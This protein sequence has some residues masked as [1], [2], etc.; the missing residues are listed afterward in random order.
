MLFNSTFF[1]FIF[2]PITLF[3]YYFF[4]NSGKLKIAQTALVFFS[5]FFY[6]WWNYNYFFLIIV[7]ILFNYLIGK[8]LLKKKKKLILIFG[9]LSNLLV[10]FY[11]KYHNFFIENINVIFEK[12]ILIFQIILPLG[13]SFFTFQQIS[14]LIEAF[15]KKN[16]EKIDF[17]R[18][19]LFVVF[20]PQ[21]IAG[22]ITRFDNF[23]PQLFFFKKNQFFKNISIGISIFSLGLF[24]KVCIA[25]NLGNYVD[26]MY[27]FSLLDINLTFFEAW[28]GTILYS[29]QLYFDFSGY[30]DMAFGLA[31]M[32]GL[33]I[34]INF[35]SPYKAKNINEFW[36][37]WHI[38]LS[39]FAR[40]YVFNPIGISFT[41]TLINFNLNKKLYIFLSFSFPT[42]ICFFCIGIWHGAGWNFIVFGLAHA[43]FIILH[44]QWVNFKKNF[45]F[46]NKITTSNIFS[47][48][49]IIINFLLVTLL[50]VFFRS[51][52]LSQSFFILKSMLG[53]NGISLPTFLSSKFYL[54]RDFGFS[55]DGFSTNNIY[56][57]SN[58]FNNAFTWIIFSSLLVFYVKN[59]YEL[60]NLEK[61]KSQLSKL[62]WKPDLKWV[63]F[64]S[65]IF[66]ISVLNISGEIRFLYFQF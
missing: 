59:V 18:Y 56:E 36:K 16:L 23:Y 50:F 39:S 52:N 46:I 55:F 1:I 43:F 26:A 13:I 66:L 60:F 47:R 33:K 22:P 63:I 31:F 7:S 8:I 37:R 25:D 40:D 41:R 14:F 17:Y 32:F 20:F 15:S 34:P 61:S 30:S 64:I 45:F 35:L 6:G 5:L 11:F 58:F 24:K 12:N 2:L 42:I 9:I 44:S 28:I 48:F 54:L 4:I 10:I 3:F 57:F 19:S 65:L 38:S 21:L 51:E 49:S 29:F 27:S 62:L 53:L